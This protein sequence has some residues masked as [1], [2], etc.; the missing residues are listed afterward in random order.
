MTEPHLPNRDEVRAAYQQGEEAVVELVNGLIKIIAGLAERVQVLEDQLAKNSRNSGKP[1]SSDGLKKPRP[2]SLRKSSGKK[3]GGQPGHQGHT[4]KAVAEPDHIEV[5]PVTQ[6]QHCHRSLVDVCAPDYEKRQVFDLPPVRLEVT[7]YRAEIK[8]CPGCGQVS[9]ADFPAEVSQPVQYGPVLKSQAVYFNQYHFIPLERTGEILAD[10]YG[11]PVADNTIITAGEMIAQQVAPINSRVKAY[12]I[13]TDE[14]VHFDETGTAVTGRLQW[15]H[16]ASTSWVTYLA[17]HAKRGRQAL[18]EIGILPDRRGKSIHDDYPSYFQY[19]DSNHGLCNAHHL[20]RL[21]FIHE[22]YQQPWAEALGQLLVEIKTTVDAA[23]QQGLSYLTDDQLRTFDRRYDDLIAQGL[24]ANPPPEPAEPR[25]KKR[26]RPKQSPA[27]NL[28]DR[29]QSHKATVLAFMYDFKVP[30]D[31][32]QAER[33]LRMVKL[34]QK[35]SG[36]FRSEDGAQVFCQIRSYIST[37]RKNGQNIL[38]ALRLALLGSPY[39]PEFLYPQASRP[40]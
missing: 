19:P 17:G 30:F 37:A 12:L 39:C 29:L 2:R 4:L 26:G 10:L 18:D 40:A 22:R 38:E 32:N 33:D 31:N 28:L 13:A 21:I 15:V 36:C 3:S 25:P 8:A 7:E 20:R 27:K 11:Q 34:K 6:C 24:A 14:P 35:M 16:V 5:H 1:P 9:R 23:K